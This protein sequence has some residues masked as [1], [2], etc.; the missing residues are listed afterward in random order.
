VISWSVWTRV[1][2]TTPAE[3]QVV[4]SVP[5]ADK[6]LVSAPHKPE[7]PYSDD[8]HVRTV[9][10]PVQAAKATTPTRIRRSRTV[11]KTIAAQEPKFTKEEIYAYDQ[12]MLA[13]SIT[14]D[15]LGQVRE[16]AIGE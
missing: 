9:P 2:N 6:P 13:L 8:I 3:D 10:V 14:S 7:P 12:L 16:K 11:L 1:S 5:N 4:A 15:K